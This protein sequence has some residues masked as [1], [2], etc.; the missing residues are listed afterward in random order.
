[1]PRKTIKDNTDEIIDK[2]EKVLDDPVVE[3]DAD[4]IYSVL[5]DALRRNK[6]IK[7]IAKS[8]PARDAD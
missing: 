6:N 4:Q 5:D 2:A 8:N 7:R 1:M 3:D